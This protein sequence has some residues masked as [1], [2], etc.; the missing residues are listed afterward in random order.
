L[1]LIKPIELKTNICMSTFK[2]FEEII[3]WKEARE[4][5]KIIGKL[6]DDEKFKKSTG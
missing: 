2:R 5:N 6:V 1:G 3:S 4:L